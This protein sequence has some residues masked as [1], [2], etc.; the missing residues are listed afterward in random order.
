MKAWSSALAAELTTWPRV[1]SSVFFGFTALYRA[2]L[3]FALLPRT[4]TL[5]P[6]NSVAFKLEAAGSRL[7]ARA[8]R[9]SRI[10]FA[11]LRKARWFTF[12]LTAEADLRDALEWLLRAYEAAA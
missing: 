5:D 7:L 11:E 10:G 12:A 9:D 1:R 8:R 4:R 6:P 3:I 2:D